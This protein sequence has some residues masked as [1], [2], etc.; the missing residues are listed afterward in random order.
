MV[1]SE[2]PLDT[3]LGKQGQRETYIMMNCPKTIDPFEKQRKTPRNSGRAS[4][5]IL[6]QKNFKD[7]LPN[8]T[9]SVDNTKSNS[10]DE[11]CHEEQFP[12]MTGLIESNS[13]DVE[14]TSNPDQWLTTNTVQQ[15]NCDETTKCR[16][17]RCGSIPST[18]P[19]RGDEISSGS[20]SKGNAELL[21]EWTLYY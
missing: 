16:A 10:I 19:S 12:F 21:L 13:N 7:R 11:A 2:A 1:I 8:R 15:E 17:S 14:N 20:R 3:I 9:K 5:P 4:S 6:H 18:L